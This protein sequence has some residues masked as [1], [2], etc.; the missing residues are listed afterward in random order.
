MEHGRPAGVWGMGG[1]G[2]HSAFRVAIALISQFESFD[3]RAVVNMR[4][5]LLSQ[6]DGHAGHPVTPFAR[7]GARILGC[8]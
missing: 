8:V 7:S 3:R 2:V 4:E 5:V 1:Y 6:L